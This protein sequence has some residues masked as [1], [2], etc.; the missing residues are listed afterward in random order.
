MSTFEVTIEQIKVF[1]H[2][3]ADRLELAQVGLYKIVVGKG[4][5]KTGDKVLYIPEYAVLPESLI[6]A[7]NLDG[8]LAGSNKNRVKPV[9]LRGEL[10]QGLVA[11]LSF[12]PEGKIAELG[13]EADFAEVLNITKWEPEVPQSMGGDVEGNYNLVNWIDI[14]NLKKFPDMFEE[15][16]Q[17]IVDEKIHGTASLFTFLNP[18]DE[19]PEILVSSKGLGAKKL[20]LKES[21][22]NVYWTVLRE[23]NLRTLA[24]HVATYFKDE[25]TIDSTITKVAIFG[26]T[27]GSKVQDLHYGFTT[28]KLGFA[29]FDIFVDFTTSEGT[30]GIWLDPEEVLKLATD[31]N[32]PVVPRLFSGAFSI[33]KVEELATGKEQV[34]GKEIHIREGVVVRPVKRGKWDATSKIGKFVSEAYLTRKGFDGQEPTEFN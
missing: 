32:I 34:S 4:D 13:E 19:A 28:G 12:L 9:K 11:P 22:H 31:V 20:A 2:P 8:K 21:E 25:F 29:V 30:S 10:S 17:V 1:P 3:N 18:I 16:E 6:T 23:Y 26:E 15:G 27:F 24:A 33:K 7:L 14:E 5:W